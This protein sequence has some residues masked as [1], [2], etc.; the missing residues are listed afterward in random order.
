M[1]AKPY[2]LEVAF[3]DAGL[4]PAG[5]ALALRLYPAIEAWVRELPPG[6]RAD[7]AAKMARVCV[8][9]AWKRTGRDP[10]VSAAWVK[11]NGRASGGR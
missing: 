7:D 5:V 11:A 3:A 10:T 1:T 4:T 9:D 2:P 6:A 8:E